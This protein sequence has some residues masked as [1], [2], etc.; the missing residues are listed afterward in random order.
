M[1]GIENA[2]ENGPLGR[3]DNGHSQLTW[4]KMWNGDAPPRAQPIKTP[5]AVT[6]GQRAVHIR[7]PRQ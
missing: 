7:T 1:S 4:S 3:N 5:A 2:L 6:V